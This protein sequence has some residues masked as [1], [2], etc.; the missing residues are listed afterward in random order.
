MIIGLQ[1]LNE[2]GYGKAGSGLSLD[3]VYNPLGGFLPPPQDDLEYKYKIELK[4]H[5]GIEFD[6]LF[7]LANMPIKRFADFLHRRNELDGYMD[8]LVRNFNPAT[9]DNLM[10]TNYISVGWDG[11][12]YDCDF[13]QQLGIHANIPVDSQTQEKSPRSGL[14]VFDMK[15]TRD[16]LHFRVETGNHC[17]GYVYLSVYDLGYS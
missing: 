14:S 11:Q 13:N 12:V 9:V 3:L 6:A 4:E 16:F 7:T 8:L 5:F 17:F 2:Y 15:T 1:R 10:C